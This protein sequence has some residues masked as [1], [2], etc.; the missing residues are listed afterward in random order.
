MELLSPPYFDMYK[1]VS[2]KTAIRTCKDLTKLIK[3]HI[4][5]VEALMFEEFNHTVK[6]DKFTHHTMVH[7]INLAQRLGCRI[8]RK[9]LVYS[10]NV[11]TISGRSSHEHDTDILQSLSEGLQNYQYINDMKIVG[12]ILNPLFQCDEIM[13][14]AGLYTKEKFQAG[15]EELLDCMAHF[16]EHKS[17]TLV[18]EDYYATKISNK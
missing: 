14:K 11:N 7:E 13:I 12:A 16:F 9:R 3:N 8:L 6:Y 15:K 1:N 2:N 17:E 4:L 18:V 10:E 5:L